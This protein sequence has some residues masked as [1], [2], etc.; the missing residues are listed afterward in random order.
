MSVCYIVM[1]DAA[2]VILHY[3]HAAINR[4]EHVFFGAV[5]TFTADLGKA[6]MLVSTIR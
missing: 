5:L 3:K 2:D 1:C 4:V 6:A